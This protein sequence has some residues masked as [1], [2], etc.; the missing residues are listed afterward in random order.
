MNIEEGSQFRLYSREHI[1]FL[2]NELANEEYELEDGRSAYSDRIKGTC[3]KVA[4]SLRGV[5]VHRVAYPS[6]DQAS[7]PNCSY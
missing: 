7:L 4:W 6:H 2:V 5:A 3:F 1:G